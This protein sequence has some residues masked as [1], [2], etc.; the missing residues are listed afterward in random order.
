MGEGVDFSHGEHLYP[1]AP[2]NGNATRFGSRWHESSTRYASPRL[3]APVN[4]G[5]TAILFLDGL[6]CIG[7]CMKNFQRK[8]GKWKTL[9]S[10]S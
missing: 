10:E 7:K 4:S 2:L 5:R 8:D 1:V 3:A 6:F 9:A